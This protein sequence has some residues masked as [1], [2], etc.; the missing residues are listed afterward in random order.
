M[1]RPAG[2]FS[3]VR[4]ND[5]NEEGR[6]SELRD[7]LE[8]EVSMRLGEQFELFQ[9]S[10]GVSFGENWRKRLEE[11]LAESTLFIPILTPA[12]LKRPACREELENFL[13]KENE[14]DRDD[15]VLPL[16]YVETPAVTDEAR[17]NQDPLAVALFTHQY[18]DWSDLRFEPWDKSKFMRLTAIAIEI[19]KALERGALQSISSP[20][21]KAKA[22]LARKRRPADKGTKSDSD[23]EG[24]M[25]PETTIS[26]P[27]ARAVHNKSTRVEPTTLVVDPMPGRGDFTSIGAAIAA[28][29]GGERILVRPH[30]YSEGLRLDKSVE[31]IGDGKRDEIILEAEGADAILFQTSFGR[32]A[33]FTI[34]QKGGGKWYGIDIPQGQLVLEDCDISSQSLAC[35]AIHGGANPILRRNAIH[36]GSDVGLLIYENGKGTVED[37]DIFG[38]RLVGTQISSGADPVLRRNILRD[39]KEGGGVLVIDRGKGTLEDN[40]I[41][42]NAAP[43]VD[44]ANEADPILRRNRIHDGKQGGVFVRDGAKGTL[45]DN[46][47]FGNALMAVEIETLADPVL[48]RNRIHDG[49]EG[50]IIVHDNGKGTLEDNDIFGHAISQVEIRT[51]ADPVL[52]RNR[53]H[54]GGQCGV[55]VVSGGRGTLEDNDIFGNEFT[56][57]ETRE[58]GSPTLRRNRIYK[59]EMQAIWIQKDG[60]GT[61]QNNDLRDNKKGAWKI[62]AAPKNVVLE[63]NIEA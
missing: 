26:P 13:A 12:Y 56:G 53:I 30:I 44:L 60:H 5:E 20:P 39:G 16:I 37:N 63:N 17:R 31:L 29:K 19:V 35:V 58:G 33:N 2:F 62:D 55:L 25:Q 11:G 48:R 23:V 45:E 3:Y 50:G 42:G 18:R 59:N 52:R 6:L 7:K 21:K 4:F 27:K 9:D 46:D 15:L 32:V 49:K 38:N 51:K 61:F 1:S 8:K 24:I 54:D 34:R 43:G 57:V 41:F 28:A 36:D 14:L 40:D 47:I 10:K 22:E